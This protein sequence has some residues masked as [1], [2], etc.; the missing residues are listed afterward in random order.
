MKELSSSY[1]QGYKMGESFVG[2]LKKFFKSSFYP[3]SGFDVK[4]RDSQRGFK[5]SRLIS[6]LSWAFSGQDEKIRI[7]GIINRFMTFKYK[8]YLNI[9]SIELCWL[10]SFI[11]YWF[12]SHCPQ[13]NQLILK[14]L[15]LE[16]SKIMIEPPLIWLMHLTFYACFRII[17]RLMKSNGRVPLLNILHKSL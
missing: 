2:T 16:F 5:M 3:G 13:S 10:C 17:L 8:S 9:L 4:G 12:F 6:L 15:I 14:N 11:L 1:I 7:I